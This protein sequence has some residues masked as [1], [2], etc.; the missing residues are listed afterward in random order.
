MP[1]EKLKVSEMDIDIVVSPKHDKP[2][3][4][5]LLES[6]INQLTEVCKD[7]DTSIIPSNRENKNF[8]EYVQLGCNALTIGTI[9]F[10][11]F[12]NM[13]GGGTNSGCYYT[14]ESISK[15]DQI[16][17]NVKDKFDIE[18]VEILQGN[19]NN[20][21]FITIEKDKVTFGICTDGEED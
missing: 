13:D 20:I 16:F 6:T 11:E 8:T 17:E 7:I 15:L 5:E 3:F 21:E 12:G 1:E 2:K 14:D 10:D 9:S 4:S 18:G 19:W